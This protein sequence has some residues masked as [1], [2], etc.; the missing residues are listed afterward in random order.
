MRRRSEPRVQVKVSGGRAGMR[1]L[2]WGCDSVLVEAT[3]VD[4]ASA[5]NRR[6]TRRMV[7]DHTLGFVSIDEEVRM[8][9]VVTVTL[10]SFLSWSRI[11]SA[12]EQS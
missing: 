9:S 10:P 3:G 1:L 5:A 8:E 11:S 6:A 2:A 7:N 12:R 4:P